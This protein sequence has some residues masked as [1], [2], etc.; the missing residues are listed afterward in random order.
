MS[1]GYTPHERFSLKNHPDFS[2]RWV[3]ELIAT[4][5]QSSAWAT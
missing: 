3:Q 2:E 1:K 4:I 5:H